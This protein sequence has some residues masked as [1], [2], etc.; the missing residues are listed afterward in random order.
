MNRNH[1][2]ASA[3]IGAVLAVTQPV[4][5]QTLGSLHGAVSGMQAARFGGGFGTVHS[6][7]TSQA[8][9]SASAHAGARV[10]GLSRV[11]RTANTATQEAGREAGHAKADAVVAGRGALDAGEL[12]ASKANDVALG[13]TR[14]AASSS[15]ATSV[16]AARQGETQVRSVGGAGVAAGRLSTTEPVKPD[17]AG[18]RPRASVAPAPQPKRDG[19]SNL[20]ETARSVA[21]HGEID[22][23]AAAAVNASA[24]H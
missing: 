15:S 14:A 12:E 11:E 20:A 7:A 6:A 2:F 9:L 13:T 19:A 8:A 5:A 3:A 22:A 16:T 10:D 1:L 18:S 21:S 4:H 17:K 23:N 24:A